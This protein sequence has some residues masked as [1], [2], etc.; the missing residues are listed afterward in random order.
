MS[1]EKIVSSIGYIV[2]KGKEM[3]DTKTVYRSA[4]RDLN[5]VMSDE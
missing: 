4:S 5:T 1:D 3:Q 2:K